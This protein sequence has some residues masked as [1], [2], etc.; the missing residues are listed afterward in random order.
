MPAR[1][2]L[3]DDP[4]DM[5]VLLRAGLALFGLAVGKPFFVDELAAL[6]MS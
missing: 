4:A 5:R 3:I 1:R 2:D 6:S